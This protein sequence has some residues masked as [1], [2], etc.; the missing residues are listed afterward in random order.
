MNFVDR[1]F[2]FLAKGLYL[3]IASTRIVHSMIVKRL[4]RLVD[5]YELAPSLS[6]FH[7]TVAG[8]S[9]SAAALSAS[10]I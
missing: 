6:G 7:S 10:R 5:C 1:H 9:A 2:P 3:V 4:S 8:E